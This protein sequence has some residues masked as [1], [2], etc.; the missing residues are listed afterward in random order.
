MN[1]FIIDYPIDIMRHGAVS[2]GRYDMTHDVNRR[3]FLAGTGAIGVAGALAL[4]GGTASARPSGDVPGR[5]RIAITGGRVYSGTGLRDPRA[6]AVAVATD[7]TILAV[8]SDRQIREF[9]GARTE[10]LDADGGT[11]MAGI[12][13]G[14]MHPLGAAQQSLNPSL[15]NAVLTVDELQRTIQ[16]LLDAEPDAGPDQWLQVTDWN[17]VG[18]LPAGTVAHRSQLDALRTTRPIYLQGSD[19]HNS[20]VNSRALQLAGVS[21]ATPDPEGGE[22]VR[23][24]SGAPTG[25]LKD[26]GQDAVRE[27]IPGPSP[28]R[29]AVAYAQMAD[30]LLSR[31]VTSFLDAAAGPDSADTYSQLHSRGVLKQHVTPA[32]V[33]TAKDSADTPETVA[34]LAGIRRAHRHNPLLRITTTKMFVDGV[35]EFPAQTAAML[36]PYLDANG[37]P[38]DNR[39]DLY[40]TSRQYA[41]LA[42]ALQRAGWQM[43]SHAIGDRAVRTALDA[44]EAAARDDLDRARRLGHTITHLELVHPHDY[45]RFARNGVLASFQL[46]WA[47]RN[48]FTLDA[49]RP[50]IGEERFDRLYPSQSLAQAGACLVGGSDWPV[51][52]FNPFNQIATAIDRRDP[53]GDN[54][55]PLGP[56]EALTRDQSLRMHTRGAARQLHSPLTGTVEPGMTADLMVLDRDITSIPVD[57]IRSTVVMNT[58]IGGDVVYDASTAR[59]ARVRRVADGMSQAATTLASVGAGS[60]TPGSCCQAHGH[61]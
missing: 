18:L 36:T 46:Q 7:G 31:G 2:I 29:L 42:V 38:T 37:R 58:L 53:H 41:K 12:H 45:G 30:Y 44:Y 3:S 27:V 6:T 39:G 9:V 25:L 17:P 34:F 14:H 13:D 33:L 47:V 8:G 60:R 20:F 21:A 1:M 51:D 40:I 43:H 49:L 19:F 26:S 4:S 59:A 54:P 11:I 48:A 22:I 24:G 5:V 10:V 15:H 28:E 56:D 35:M 52:P 61:G 50:Y 32:F 57:A 23:D 55:R 16:G